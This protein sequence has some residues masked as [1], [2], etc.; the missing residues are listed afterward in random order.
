MKEVGLFMY[1]EGLPLVLHFCCGSPR[2]ANELEAVAHG[3]PDHNPR[4]CFTLGPCVLDAFIVFTRSTSKLLCLAK[5]L[6]HNSS[7]SRDTRGITSSAIVLKLDHK[8]HDLQLMPHMI[9]S[10]LSLNSCPMDLD[11]TP[12]DDA[13]ITFFRVPQF[14]LS[15]LCSCMLSFGIT[16]LRL[17][18]Y[19]VLP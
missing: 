16:S 8:A 2:M 19:L 15:S 10:V 12:V 1:C 14:A 7:V 6:L 18:H 13:M 4:V 9:P 3:N 11:L 17:G 5:H